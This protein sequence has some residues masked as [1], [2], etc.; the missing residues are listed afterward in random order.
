M[1]PKNNFD[2]VPS[3]PFSQPDW[4]RLVRDRREKLGW[5]QS[6]LAQ[7]AGV[8]YPTIQNLEGGKRVS[9][10]VCDRVEAAFYQPGVNFPKVPKIIS[11]ASPSRGAP[12]AHLFAPDSPQSP[13]ELAKLA[14]CETAVRIIF[15]ASDAARTAFLDR[16]LTYAN[17]LDSLE[18]SKK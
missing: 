8:S 18:R 5:S 12:L 15:A 11:A 4:G 6:T 17:T 16:L 2:A 9:K 14:D 1:L 3:D 10:P 7:R 13:S